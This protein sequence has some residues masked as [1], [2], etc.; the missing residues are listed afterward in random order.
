MPRGNRT[1]PIGMGPMSGRAAGYCAG[2]HTAGSENRPLWRDF[3]SGFAQDF[4]LGGRGGGYGWR[5]MFWATELPGW[6]RLG[7]YSA[8]KPNSDP[9]RERQALKHQAEDLQSQLDLI[10][11]R[12]NELDSAATAE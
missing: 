9:A 11:K 2:F 5:H 4:G 12:L 6:M 8:P 7:K 10:N 1:G 3:R